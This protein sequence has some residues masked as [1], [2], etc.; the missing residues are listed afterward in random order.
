MP[1]AAL[2]GLNAVQSSPGRMLTREGCGLTSGQMREGQEAQDCKPAPEMVPP[3]IPQ[4]HIAMLTPPPLRQGGG[5]PQLDQPPPLEGVTTRYLAS[6]TPQ[7]SMQPWA[8][9][10]NWSG[11]G[12]PDGLAAMDFSAVGSGSGGRTGSSGGGP[13][14]ITGHK[15]IVPLVGPPPRK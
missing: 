9:G 1:I 10:R 7:G 8:T 3:S 6:G 2:A 12:A 15:A 11:V 4:I 5:I 13:G 14:A